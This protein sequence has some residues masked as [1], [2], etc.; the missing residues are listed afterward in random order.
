MWLGS[1]AA[2]RVWSLVHIGGPRLRRESTYRTCRSSWWNPQTS[3]LKSRSGVT[4]LHHLHHL[5]THL[6]TETVSIYRR[7]VY[8][9]QPNQ[10]VTTDRPAPLAFA[11]DMARSQCGR[12]SDPQVRRRLVTPRTQESCPIAGTKS[13]GRRSRSGRPCPRKRRPP[14]NRYLPLVTFAIRL[15]FRTI[16]RIEMLVETVP[17]VVGE[18][19]APKCE[20]GVYA[21]IRVGSKEIIPEAVQW[22]KSSNSS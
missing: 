7:S 14:K 1:S 4:S 19:G 2:R 11:G 17:L 6:P 3:A 10:Q 21:R 12:E 20:R 16:G 18:C 8:F 15:S 22:S 5:A 9:L 13:S